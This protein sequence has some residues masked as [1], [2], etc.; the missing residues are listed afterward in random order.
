MANSY[1]CLQVPIST[2][3]YVTT[4][5]NGYVVLSFILCFI[6]AVVVVV[7]FTK[8]VIRKLQLEHER[9]RQS[10]LRKTIRMKTFPINRKKDFEDTESDSG[11]HEPFVTNY[12][13]LFDEPA[14]IKVEAE[15]GAVDRCHSN[16][17]FEMVENFEQLQTRLVHSETEPFVVEILS[18]LFTSA[19]NS[20]DATVANQ[21][22]SPLLSAFELLVGFSQEVFIGL[23][24]FMLTALLSAKKINEQ[25]KLQIMARYEQLMYE[26]IPANASN[27]YTSKMHFLVAKLK[28]EMTGANN[29]SDHGDKTCAMITYQVCRYLTKF[30]NDMLAESSNEHIFDVFSNREKGLVNCIVDKWTNLETV[31]Y[32]LNVI[33]DST[34][35]ILKKKNVS[36]DKT[37]MVLNN[38]INDIY[39]KM[40]QHCIEYETEIADAIEG[41]KRE[42]ISN[43][44]QAIM[45][46]YSQRMEHKSHMIN[47]LGSFTKNTFSD[48]FISQNDVLIDSFKTCI[49]FMMFADSNSLKEFA[50]HVKFKEKK[51]MKSLKSCEEELFSSLQQD[52]LLYEE[53]MILFSKSTTNSLKD[54]RSSHDQLKLQL[55][56]SYTKN[57]LKL[58]TA[59]HGIYTFLEQKFLLSLEEVRSQCMVILH[60]LSNLEESD[61][62][63]IEIDFEIAFSSLQFSC[64]YTAMSD[65]ISK[66]HEHIHSSLSS[67]LTKDLSLS[68]QDMVA[69]LKQDRNVLNRALLFSTPDPNFYLI[70][71]SDIVKAIG[72]LSCLVENYT[73][74]ISKKVFKFAFKQCSEVMH[75]S[76]SCQSMAYFSN[77]QLAKEQMKSFSIDNRGYTSSKASQLVKNFNKALSGHWDSQSDFK[78]LKMKES[79]QM[80]MKDFT[81][82]T[83]NFFSDVKPLNHSK[84]SN[85]F[86][87]GLEEVLKQEHDLYYSFE[88]HGKTISVKRVLDSNLENEIMVKKFRERIESL[89]TLAG[90]ELLVNMSNG[91]KKDMLKKRRPRSSDSPDIAKSIQKSK[92]DTLSGKQ[93][94]KSKL[95]SLKKH[96]VRK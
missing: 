62:N 66:L 92:V 76:N 85:N 64:Y 48:F 28:E 34:E 47:N 89:E 72:P 96:S 70:I 86:L 30:Q 19:A 81:L 38:Y 20:L 3:K 11:V 53:D 82:E 56:E 55:L 42:K 80:V 67:A 58:K 78:V 29:Q 33:Y 51:L 73:S 16:I 57:I 87:D 44:K 7:L 17:S 24:D 36:P 65:I 23:L 27:N 41:I 90:S 14:S 50:Q 83:S 93:S 21:C 45:E 71:K 49:Q 95:H 43:Y 2:T 37:Q 13:G 74:A 54:F 10:E 15:L 88:N 39:G 79:I 18:S 22:Y 5:A 26:G 91:H 4:I 63:E 61:M 46:L 52:G 12:V 25:E 77:L 1:T 60:S 75:K 69:I 9:E 84:V 35:S 40:N 32:R 94:P 31:R 68:L 59:V 6:L 8:Y